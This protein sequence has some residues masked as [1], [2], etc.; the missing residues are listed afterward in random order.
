VKKQRH[1]FGQSLVEFA[2][3]FPLVIFLIFGMLDLGRAIFYYS[4]LSNAVR[5]ATRYA[6]VHRDLDENLIKDKVLEYAFGLNG[7]PSSLDPNNILVTYPEVVDE[8]KITISVEA[9]YTFI[10]ITPGITLLLGSAEGI[11]L[12]VQ[13][14]MRISGAAR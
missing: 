11:E 6:I 10:P 1:H 4:S 14:T 7:T 12:F 9:T 5:E 2:F 13:S 8:K 3:V